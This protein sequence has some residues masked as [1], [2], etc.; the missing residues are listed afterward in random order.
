MVIV[1]A[2]V[3]PEIKAKLIRRAEAE[4]RSVNQVLSELVTKYLGNPPLPS[5]DEQRKL[6]LQGLLDD[7]TAVFPKVLDEKLKEYSD[8]IVTDVINEIAELSKKLE[9]QKEKPPEKPPVKKAEEEEDE[10][11]F[12]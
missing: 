10:W 5:I 8:E 9:G 11:T 3:E 2:Q 7:A 1:G 6:E 12:L 4:G